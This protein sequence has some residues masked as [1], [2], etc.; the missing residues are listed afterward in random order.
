MR[1]FKMVLAAALSVLI[2]L[3][4]SSGVDAAEAIRV[5]RTLIKP[6][7]E[8]RLTPR[9]QYVTDLIEAGGLA[10]SV[11]MPLKRAQSAYAADANGCIT[12]Q[13][14]AVGANEIESRPLSVFPMWLYVRADF[15][16][17]PLQDIRTAVT[18][19]GS[20]YE[21]SFA[22]L[23]QAKWLYAQTYEDILVKLKS[24]EAD[25]GTFG[26][27][28]L[29]TVLKGETSV[30]RLSDGPHAM[31]ASKVRCKNTPATR[32]FITG[33]NIRIAAGDTPKS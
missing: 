21:Y 17:V 8:I 13:L 23:V 5:Y 28:A 29:S 6:A 4:A 7:G 20:N 30:R 24:G 1:V 19:G 31:I 10:V 14:H 2:V 16:G 3:A 32:A 27:S 25:A 12:L 18:F 22:G 15:P 11:E 26:E 33:L 9:Q